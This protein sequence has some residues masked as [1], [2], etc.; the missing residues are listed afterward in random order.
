MKKLTNML[1]EYLWNEEEIP[2]ELFYEFSVKATKA[3]QTR[4]LE[5]LPLEFWE[6]EKYVE[7]FWR[8]QNF[9]S[10]EEKNIYGMGRL[11][12]ITNML[13]MVA[14]DEEKRYF[15]P[16]Y[17]EKYQEWYPVFEEMHNCPGIT[18]VELARKAHK[19]KSS[20]SQFM[21]KNQWQGFYIFHC[22]GREKTYYLTEL[23]QQLYELM[24]SKIM[25]GK[26]ER[27]TRLLGVMDNIEQAMAAVVNDYSF[28]LVKAE[29]AEVGEKALYMVNSENRR[30]AKVI[31]V[32]Y[33]KSEFENEKEKKELC[34]K[35]GSLKMLNAK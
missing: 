34:Q 20:L 24:K 5:E 1:L 18:H 16:E 11:L 6:V 15:L 30:I 3:I 13:A 14:E 8:S 23:G 26:G 9:T 22:L 29:S 19:S 32:H 2:E 7:A 21:K 25:Q 12:S 28:K 27:Y 10:L 33:N 31:Q 4:C 35:K 17:A